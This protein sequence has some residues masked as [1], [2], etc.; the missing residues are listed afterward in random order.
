MPKVST[1]L[2][3]KDSNAFTF[4]NSSQKSLPRLPLKDHVPL[5]TF[6]SSL[7]SLLLK[8]MLRVDLIVI[9]MLGISFHKNK[10]RMDGP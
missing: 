9:Q 1:M 5:E 6:Q 10:L 4:K 7:L 2:L 8:K 3:G